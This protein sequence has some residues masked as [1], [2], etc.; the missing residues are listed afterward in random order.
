VLIAGLISAAAAM[1]ALIR[2]LRF[3][4]KTAFSTD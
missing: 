4:P 3:Q 1:I 2:T